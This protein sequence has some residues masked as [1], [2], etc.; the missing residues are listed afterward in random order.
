MFLLGECH[1]QRTQAGY[2]PWGRKSQTRLHDYTLTTTESRAWEDL[3]SFWLCRV[4]PWEMSQWTSV[5]SGRWGS[6]T[7]DCDGDT[8]L[9]VWEVEAATQRE[10]MGKRTWATPE[11]PL[12][13]AW[14]TGEHGS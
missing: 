9:G 1:G 12:L 4:Q 14:G 11:E 10:R 2:S 8:H 3:R 13:S 7:G 5:F 6:R